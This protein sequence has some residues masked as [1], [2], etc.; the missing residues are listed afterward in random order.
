MTMTGNVRG[1]RGGFV[2]RTVLKAEAYPPAY[3]EYIWYGT[4]FYAMLGGVWGIVIPIVGGAVWVIVAASCFLSVGLKNVNVYE[5]ISWALCTGALVIAIGVIFHEPGEKAQLEIVAFLS[6]LSLLIT[7]QSLSLRPGFLQRFALVAFAIG[8]ASLPYINLR[9]AGQVT[10]AFATGTGLANGNILGMWFGFC[11]V[12][13]IFWGF[14][15][16]KPT[17]R[18]ASW[19]AALGCL[20]MVAITVSRGPLLAI[21]LACIVGFRSALKQSFLP[22]FMF[23]LLISLVY[24]SGIFDTE[25]GYYMARAGER[26]GR[27]K[28]WPAALE[29]ILDSPWIGVGL[30]DIKVSQRA[31]AY[32]KP[33]NDLLHIALGSGIVPLICFLG[34]LRRAAIGA[35]RIMQASHLGEAAL[36][37]PLV[38]FALLEIMQLDLV[39]MSPWTVVALGLAVRAAQ[40][41]DNNGSAIA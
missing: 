18:G 38:V 16:Q 27:E 35:F 39:F 14:H 6:W 34:Y 31:N 10:R 17:L 2:G 23:V 5:P 33:H 4:L 1:I 19:T 13:F 28:L 22:L 24:A 9:G 36:I 41:N 40:V 20:Y 30:D 37:P 21:I 8:L 12:Y 15:Q 25:I 7:V 29:R 26:S 11:T 3:L 32:S